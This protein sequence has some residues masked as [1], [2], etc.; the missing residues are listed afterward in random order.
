MSALAESGRDVDQDTRA[1]AKITRVKTRTA[2]ARREILMGKRLAG[3][4]TEGNQAENECMTELTHGKINELNRPAVTAFSAGN[5]TLSRANPIGFV[6]QN[7]DP[8]I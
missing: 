3:L 7:T 5:K 4:Q 1:T 6:Q 2:S 8:Q